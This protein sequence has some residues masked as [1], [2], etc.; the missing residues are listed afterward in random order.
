MKGGTLVVSRLTKWFPF[1]KS[2][3]EELGYAD[4]ITTDKE[5]DALNMFINQIKPKIVLIDSI[6]YS[7]GT[8]FMVYKLIKSFR[9]IHFSVFSFSFFPDN[10]AVWFVFY[11]VESYVKMSDGPDE[12]NR[13]LK[14]IC[15][16]KKYIPPDVQELVDAFP[17]LPELKGDV[18]NRHND[19]L[20]L[21]CNGMTTL[22]ISSN[23]HISKRTVDWHIEELYKI[24]NVHS[25]EALI[26]MAFYLDVISKDDI[27]FTFAKKE[28]TLKLPAWAENQRKINKLQ[29]RLQTAKIIDYGGYKNGYQN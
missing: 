25:R 14:C 5:K 6:F 13:G 9:K 28:R 29:R 22:E 10:R 20:L 23:L 3:L 24:F 16:G 15:E 8:P 7:G 11:G 4:V 19:V 17:E 18:E 1:F 27:S 26:G 21:L 2:Y 12:L